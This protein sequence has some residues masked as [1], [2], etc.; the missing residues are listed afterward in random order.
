MI[1]IN[2]CCQCYYTWGDLPGGLSLLLFPDENFNP[3][4]LVPKC[5]NCFNTYWVWINYKDFI[6]YHS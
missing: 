6:K 2:N 4:V 5:P 1:A 3:P